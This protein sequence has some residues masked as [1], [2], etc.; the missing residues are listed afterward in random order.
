MRIALHG[1]NPFGHHLAVSVRRA[2]H[3]LVAGKM[4][5]VDCDVA[6]IGGIRN[7]RLIDEYKNIPCFIYEMGYINRTNNHTEHMTGHWQ[8]SKGWLN[9]LPDFECP[10]DRFDLLD[11]PI[12]N[13]GGDPYGY[14]LVLGQKPGDSALNGTDHVR[15][16]RDRF[17]EYDD[18]VYRPHPKSGYGFHDDEVVEQ[19]GTLE[20]AFAGARLVVCYNSTAGFAALL[21]GIP[22][23]CNECA[24]YAELSGIEIPSVVVRRSFFNRA[25]YGQWLVA[26]TDQAIKFVTEKWL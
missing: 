14:V 9:G 26:E 2:G 15:W 22:V 18:V 1:Q 12:I 20:E 21:A 7:S 17:N 4:N 23:L 24:P 25:A 16:L 19:Q 3:R 8:L 5:A 6:L 13:H 11:T 10:G